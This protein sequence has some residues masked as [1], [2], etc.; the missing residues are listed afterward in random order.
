MT[1]RPPTYVVGVDYGT[2]SGRAVVVRVQDGTEVGA[3]E[4]PYPHAVID[5]RLPA[6]GEALPPDWALQDPDDYVSVLRTAV[7]AAL[8]DAG[9]DAVNLHWSEWSGGMVTLFHRFGRVAFGWDAQYRRQLD[10]LIEM[11]IDG[12]FSDHV[13][14]MVDALAGRPPAPEPE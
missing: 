14:R 12:V 2:L 4:L 3:A 6:T 1:D 13:E 10:V 9:V 7:P 11:G 5:A 8:A